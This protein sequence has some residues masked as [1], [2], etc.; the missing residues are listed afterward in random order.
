MSKR[1]LVVG[2]LTAMLTLALTLA[3][4]QQRVP[5]PLSSRPTNT[6]APATVAPTPRPTIVKPT[7]VPQ[8]ASSAG[9]AVWQQAGCGICH[10]AQGQG[11]IGPA[12][13]HTDLTAAD[14]VYKTRNATP[15]M[16]VFTAADVDDA[17]L[18]S[19]YT[20]LQSMPAVEQ[21]AR[22][23]G[24][25]IVEVLPGQADLPDGPILGMSVWSGL[26]CESC[27][28]VFA[29]GSK[30]VIL[31]LAGLSDPL[32]VVLENL[33]N[34]ADQIPEHAADYITDPVFE[35][36]YQWLQSGADPQAGC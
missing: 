18:L 16:P 33:R 2:L 13:A 12:M 5:E 14:L 7:A 36:L 28:G 27:H 35:R 29:Q 31:P 8:T 23:T 1:L 21:V 17:A 11:N 25:A 6:P 22:T 3:G 19:I 10:G 34:S 9:Y 4:C 20:W 24:P 15:P 26:G 30:E 32:S